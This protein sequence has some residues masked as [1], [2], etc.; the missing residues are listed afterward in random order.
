MILPNTL[1]RRSSVLISPMA[2]LSAPAA[3]ESVTQERTQSFG[4][5][6]QLVV[7]GATE[8]GVNRSSYSAPDGATPP[9]SIT[10]LLIDP[11]ADFFV[12]HG[13]SLGA[14]LAY[15]HGEEAGAP[16]VDTFFFGPRVGYNVTFDDHFSFWP[17]ASISHFDT[18]ISGGVHGQGFSV[19]GYAPLLYH[20]APHFFVGVGPQL[21]TDLTS[22]STSSSLPDSK[23]PLLTD[24]GIQ[25][26]LGG[27][28]VL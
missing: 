7:T 26:T 19:S 16:S 28:L 25:F 12:L 8:L 18:W 22:T 13:L 4:D 23:T 11:S 20:P 10:S 1:I 9:P 24:Y 17:T 3:A 27:W 2:L 5:A 21:V 14:R 15:S 6:G